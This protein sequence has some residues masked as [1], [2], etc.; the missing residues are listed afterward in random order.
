M[1]VKSFKDSRFSEQFGMGACPREVSICTNS[2]VERINMPPDIA[3]FSG[4]ENSHATG[5]GSK[6][7]G[8]QELHGRMTMLPWSPFAWN[9]N[10][11]TQADS[12][13]C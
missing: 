4:E 9:E 13:Y 11:E 2:Y 12:D 8:M 10:I 5:Q 3:P 7:G 1:P 6:K